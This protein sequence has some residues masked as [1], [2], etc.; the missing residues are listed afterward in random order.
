[1]RFLTYRE[2]LKA[3]YPGPV[4]C[5]DNQVCL[6]GPEKERPLVAEHTIFPPMPEDVM[7]HLCDSYKGD[8]PPQLLELYRAANG[9]G[10]FM[11]YH[12]LEG[13][14]FR[15]PCRRLNIYGVPLTNSRDRLEPFNISLEDLSRLPKTPANWLK[16]GSFQMVC[17]GTA[18]EEFE[19]FADT[20]TGCAYLCPRAGK[21]ISVN[22]QWESIDDC[23]C[24]LFERLNQK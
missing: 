17:E 24:D 9:M 5:T 8:I 16:F 14:N 21:C 13:I 19:L 2:E 6:L 1:M 22:Q 11:V 18:P 7:R 3:N 4:A 23:L 12:Q 10:L 15:L 20:G